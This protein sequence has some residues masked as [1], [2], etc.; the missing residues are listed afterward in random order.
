MN[1]RIKRSL[2]VILVL[3]LSVVLLS[4]C[5]SSVSKPALVSKVT[6]YGIEYGS[7]KKDWIETESYEYEYADAY[8]SVLR[9]REN[10]EEHVVKFNYEFKDGVP[11]RMTQN[12]PRDDM[13]TLDVSYTKKGLVSRI[14][15]IENT[16]RKVGEKVFQYG[17]RDGYFTLVLHES[18]ISSASDPVDDHMEE[19]DSV[20]VTGK[21]GLLV[22]TVNNGLFA[23]YNDNEKKIWRR[24]DGTYTANYDSNGIVE[25][26]TALFRTFP[27]SGNMYKFDL[28]IKD[29]RVTEAVRNKWADAGTEGDESSS[30]TENEGSWEPECKYVF[31]YTDTGISRER[32]AS[33]I[34]CFLLDG[35][36]YYYIFNWY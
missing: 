23:N 20:Q 35:G 24:F 22:K 5:A 28:T 34:N 25:N 30:G 9:F 8:P 2:S 14:R 4:S 32:Y 18:I 12:D 3:V 17:N 31:E 7:D 36:S 19:I 21:D 6:I 11:V 29:G 27:G 1:N 16:G 15:T 13:V 10:G 33:M 26:T